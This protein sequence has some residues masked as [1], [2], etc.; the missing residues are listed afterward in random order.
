MEINDVVQFKIVKEPVGE[1]LTDI[2][3]NQILLSTMTPSIFIVRG[4]VAYK[5]RMYGLDDHSVEHMPTSE[6]T[7]IHKDT[8]INPETADL[9]I[10]IRDI[11]KDY[12]HNKTNV[13]VAL[14]IDDADIADYIHIIDI[15]SLYKRLKDNVGTSPY[16]LDYVSKEVLGLQ[17]L[18]YNSCPIDKYVISVVGMVNNR[19]GIDS[20]KSVLTVFTAKCL[21][22]VEHTI[23]CSTT[24]YDFNKNCEVDNFGIEISIPTDNDIVTKDWCYQI[25]DKVKKHLINNRVFKDDDADV[26]VYGKYPQNN[27]DIQ[28]QYT[29]QNVL[30]LAAE[31]QVSLILDYEDG[32]RLYCI[33]IIGS[34]EVECFDTGKYTDLQLAV[35]EAW[36]FLTNLI[37]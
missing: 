21:H 8:I 6:Y 7:I 32:P 30:Q 9:Y 5:C 12:D 23:T 18:P 34:A 1:Y 37:N 26:K 4:D 11:Q 28:P 19:V 14:K 13:T 17:K 15:A 36:E 2:N 10:S 24:I 25:A 3:G 27:E 22:N 33:R 29:L 31:R 35:T 20:I 16:A